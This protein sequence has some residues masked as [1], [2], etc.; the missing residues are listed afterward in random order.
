MRATPLSSRP[1]VPP[2]DDLRAHLCES[3]EAIP[4]RSVL[5]ISSKVVAIG[6]G[7]CVAIPE[8]ADPKA[9]KDE[10]AIRE[11]EYYIPRP[12]STQSASRLF[13]LKDHTLIG[14]AG[15][16]ESNGNGYLILHPEDAMGAAHEIRAF[17]AE[18]FDVQE[19][20]V[21]ITDSTSTPMRNGT[22]GITLGYAG[23]R[24]QYD[25]RGTPDIFGRLVRSERMN[26][27][28]CLASV[29]TVSMGE[30]GECTPFVVIDDIPH[31]E[32]AET[33]AD[34]P[35][36]TL[37]VSLEE[38]VFSPFFKDAPWQPGGNA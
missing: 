33:E 13:T 22:I 11:A 28:D 7:R 37:S 27:A 38:D 9:F 29:A 32:F 15:V 4:E 36:L 16:D 26:V 8:G 35:F 10:V 24:A 2:R 34:D 17:L 5:A 1:F 23:F 14:S 12:V 20:G 6:Q 31:I 18:H 3:I 30:G 25:Y 21:L 19:L